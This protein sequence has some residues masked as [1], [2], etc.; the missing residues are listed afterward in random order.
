VLSFLKKF[1][2]QLFL[3]FLFFEIGSF[4][5]TKFEL[6]LVNITPSF[7]KFKNNNLPDIILGR[8]ENEKFGAWHEKNKSFAHNHECFN[9]VMNFN[10]FG[11]RDE[12]FDING[13]DNI[14]L[15]GDSFA[16]GFGVNYHNTSQYLIEKNINK[17]ILNFGTSGSFGPLQQ[18]ILYNEFKDLINHSGL[19]IFILPANDF[20][21][22]DAK[23]WENR[24]DRYRPYF[25][26]GPDPLIP[27]YF[28]S[29]N[30]KKNL[31]FFKSFIKDYLWSS[32][33]IRSALILI[34]GDDEILSPGLSISKSYYYDSL[35]YQQKNFILAH[36]KIT[37]LA[38]NRDILFVVIP[39]KNDIKNYLSREN[40][41]SYKTQIW[42][43]GLEEISKKKNVQLMD[44]MDYVPND[45]NNLFLTCDDHWGIDGNSWAAKEISKFIKSKNIFK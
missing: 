24:K 14:F 45:Y 39:D 25:S 38:E 5:A 6:F 26:S 40:K 23:F 1:L 12:K 27:F 11:A 18:L 19:I 41:N 33:A 36:N 21:D 10:E 8:T 30:T 13:K 32:N 2:V 28:D 44:L 29:A 37:E 4:I 31:T 16:E 20:T 15:I 34:R 43:K 7:Y 42:F 3:L 17:K 35:D 22:N 9:V